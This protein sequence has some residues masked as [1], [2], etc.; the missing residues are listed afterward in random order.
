MSPDTPRWSTSAVRIN[1]ISIPA[2]SRR[3]AEGQQ[4]HLAG[5]LD[6]D[7]DVTLVLHA[8][9]GHAAGADL[10]ALA[11]VGAQQRG[12]LVVDVLPLLGAERTL[13]CLDRLFR[14]GAPRSEEHT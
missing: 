2:L 5:I 14:R 1:F 4:R 13:A 9:T 10:A 8:V 3:R 7:R 12:V 11:D 6:R